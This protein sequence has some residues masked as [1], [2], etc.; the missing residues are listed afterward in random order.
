MSRMA[1]A[2]IAYF[3]SCKANEI[4]RRYRKN[5][6]KEKEKKGEKKKKKTLLSFVGECL[7]YRPSVA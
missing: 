4:R 1:T 2:L 3:P 5:Q 6:E 7:S